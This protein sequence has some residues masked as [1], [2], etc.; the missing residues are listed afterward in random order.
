[1]AVSAIGR[2]LR[3]TLTQ[4]TEESASGSAIDALLEQFAAP[5]PP[6]VRDSETA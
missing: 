5:V 4:M 6:T 3:E 2:E 1:M